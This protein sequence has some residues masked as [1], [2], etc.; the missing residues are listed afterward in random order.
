[1][2]AVVATC[3]I[4]GQ[5]WWAIAQDKRKPDSE[6]TNG[7]VAVRLLE[8]H[9]SQ[10]LQEAVH[11]L[12]RVARAVQLSRMPDDP[13]AIQPGRHARHRP[14]PP[15]QGTAV[16]VPQGTSWI[17]SPDYP[18]HQSRLARA[19]FQYLLHNPKDHE[20]WW[21]TPMPAPTTANG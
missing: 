18:T 15:P 19:T 4:F 21:A 17:S 7:L 16:R 11:T 13:V 14:Q 9:A 2:F 1:L 3:A 8:E 12:D 10:T 20:P 5:T 6:T